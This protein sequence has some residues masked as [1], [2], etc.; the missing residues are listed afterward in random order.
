MIKQ[1]HLL[2]LALLVSFYGHTIQKSP[3]EG[4]ANEHLRCFTQT[5]DP[6]LT[7]EEELAK[8]KNV[9]LDTPELSEH[10]LHTHIYKLLQKTDSSHSNVVNDNVRR[11]LEIIIGENKTNINENLLSYV[12]NCVTR[13]GTDVLGLYLTHPTS[14]ISTLVA[15]QNAIKELNTNTELFE[16]LNI[17]LHRAKDAEKTF[18]Y[19]YEKENPFNQ[20]MISSF[21]FNSTLPVLKNLKG[22]NSQTGTMQAITLAGRV[23]SALYIAGL[24]MFEYTSSFCLNTLKETKEPIQGFKHFLSLIKKHHSIANKKAFESFKQNRNPWP[25]HLK[26]TN[27]L[28]D[29]YYNQPTADSTFSWGDSYKYASLMDNHNNNTIHTKIAFAGDTFNLGLKSYLA[30]TGYQREKNY[31][32]LTNYLQNQLIATANIVR[33]IKECSETIQNNTTLQNSL[34]HHQDLHVLFDKTASNVSYKLHKLVHLLLTNTFTG[35]ASYF[36]LKGRVLAAYSLM[37]DVKN[38]LAPALRALGEVD[39]LVSTTKLYRKSQDQN[40]RYSFPTYLDQEQPEIT[41]SNMWNP[42]VPVKKVITNSIALGGDTSRNVILTGPNAGGK[43]T[44]LKGISLS[45][46]M[47]QTLGISPVEELAFTPFAK[48]NTYMNITD[49]TA[50]GNSLF[51]SEVLRAQELIETVQNLNTKEFSLSIMDEI[52]SGTSPKEGAAASYGVANSLGKINNSILLLAS[53][54]PLLTE[55]EK[56]SNNFK[57]YQ[58]RV[59]RH[60]NGS[61]SYPFKLEEGIANQNVAMD[62]LKQQGFNS[63]I[64]N[65]ATKMLNR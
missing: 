15:R 35:K 32:N 18:L 64:L 23:P 38:E 43:S 4:L 63:S 49:D 60:D 24:Q 6:E 45:I 42:F 41:L 40:V 31:N 44:F 26:N 17:S 46:L 39:A 12:D 13:F 36:S 25:K 51:K 56:D 62:I 21:Y 65:D 37:Q 33:T 47:A 50:G 34:E 5:T 58:V 22:L 53:H 19:M 48:I 11:D 7:A 52:F 28:Q 27:S 14:S 30:Y 10:T 1:K 61:F 3:F 2:G 9:S 29:L 8:N 54:F 20:K 55:L 57:N 59:V 16:T